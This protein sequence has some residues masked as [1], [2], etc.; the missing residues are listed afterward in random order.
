MLPLH[1]SSGVPSY[2]KPS[3]MRSILFKQGIK[4]CPCLCLCKDQC[5]SLPY[6]QINPPTERDVFHVYKKLN[7]AGLIARFGNRH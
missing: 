1:W 7:H 2:E 5:E 3:G 6:K 4:Y